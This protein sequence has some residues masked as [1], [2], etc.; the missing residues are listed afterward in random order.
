MHL[1][2]QYNRIKKTISESMLGTHLFVAGK[3][4]L[5]PC[6]G[7]ESAALS[8]SCILPFTVHGTKDK[9]SV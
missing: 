4:N 6:F 5:I 8:L 3:W 1:Q 2:K 7:L 9:G